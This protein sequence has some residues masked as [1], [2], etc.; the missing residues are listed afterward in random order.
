M[1]GQILVISKHMEGQ[2]TSD[3]DRHQGK[4]QKHLAFYTHPDVRGFRGNI[5]VYTQ[6]RD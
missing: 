5:H 4:L 1:E 2:E 6:E 3:S